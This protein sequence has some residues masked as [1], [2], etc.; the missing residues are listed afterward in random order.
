MELDAEDRAFVDSLV[1]DGCLA[2]GL[3]GIVTWLDENG[4][5]CWRVYNQT[6]E[7]LSGLVG[8]LDMAKHKFLTETDDD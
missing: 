1:P 5:P 3:L 4:A 8:L 2:T 6:D 7:R